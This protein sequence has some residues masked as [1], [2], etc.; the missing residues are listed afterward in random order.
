MDCD[1]L[2]VGGGTGGCAAA[3][4]ACAM[5][6]RVILTEETNWI[7]GQLTSQA[8]P[9]DEHP[10]IESFGC[11]RTYRE[12]RNRVRQWYRDRLPLTVAARQSLMLNPGGGWVSRLCH[13]PRVAV[14][15]LQRMLQAHLDSGL[16]TLLYHT[17][18][19]EAETGDDAVQ[20]ITLQNSIT[21]EKIRVE[22]DFFLDATEFGDLLPMTGTEYVVGSEAR[23]QTG[24]PHAGETYRPDNCQALTWVFAMAHDE[25]SDRT[26]DKPE[27]YAKW[28]AYKPPFWP[29]PLLGEWDLDPVT[30]KRRKLPFWDKQDRNFFTYRQIVDPNLYEHSATVHPVTIV[31]WPMND[32]FEGTIID[33]DAATKSQRLN[34]SKELSKCLLYWLQTEAGLKGMYMSGDVM[35]TEDGFAKAPYIRESRRI[36]ARETVVEQHVSAQLHEG[37][38]RAIEFADSVGIGAYRIDL[39]PSTGGDSYIDLSSLPFQIPLGALIPVRMRNLLP[40]CKNL[41]VTHITNGC[42]RLHPVEWNIGEAAGYLA[43]MCIQGGGDIQDVYENAGNTRD[44]QELLVRR[45]IEIEW[46]TLRAL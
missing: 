4:A 32:Y 35:G 6:M 20:A 27:S 30:N 11:T 19:I 24:E 40:A 37:R 44:F 46:P 42:Y 9:P 33:V 17:V 41:G 16:L 34:D 2:I 8:V 26:I 13:D 3:M 29:G 31:N 28:S 7:G 5:G 36:V 23:S 14:A 15:V 22:A 18:A 12:Y 10:W 25:G 43:S 39:H 38:D 1:I 45:G 21:G